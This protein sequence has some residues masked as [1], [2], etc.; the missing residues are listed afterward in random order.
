MPHQ[1]SLHQ[2]VLSK[3]NVAD[4]ANLHESLVMTDIKAPGDNCQVAGKLHNLLGKN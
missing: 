3:K 4:H 1:F 2:P